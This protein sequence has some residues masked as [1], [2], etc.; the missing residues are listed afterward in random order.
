MD[1]L[2]KDGQILIVQTL[3]GKDNKCLMREQNLKANTS[4]ADLMVWV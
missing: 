1:T 2:Q 4:V 3:P